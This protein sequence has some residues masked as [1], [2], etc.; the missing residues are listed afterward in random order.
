MKLVAV[1]LVLSS[2]V[3]LAENANLVS[4]FFYGK[5]DGVPIPVIIDVT[6]RP[7]KGSCLFYQ[8]K[9]VGKVIGASG[10]DNN[11]SVQVTDDITPF[12]KNVKDPVLR[13][14]PCDKPVS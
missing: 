10:S 2:S 13:F 12:I 4:T 3:C 1:A 8:D 7:E 14:E 5:P 9:V 11:W 6:N